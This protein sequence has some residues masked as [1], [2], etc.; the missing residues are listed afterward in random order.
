VK[1]YLGED[2]PDRGLSPGE[3]VRITPRKADVDYRGVQAKARPDI[4]LSSASLSTTADTDDL[5]SLGVPVYRPKSRD[6]HDPL[7]SWEDLEP[8]LNN[9]RSH[10]FDLELDLTRTDISLTGPTG[11]P[12][13]LPSTPTSPLGGSV[14]KMHYHY[15]EGR[16]RS[17]ERRRSSGHSRA[18]SGER[19]SR[20]RTPTHV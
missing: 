13:V 17:M 4:L 5:S 1:A 9:R 12:V 10:N 2:S 11:Y 19:S 6:F 8:E 15:P 3:V 18:R 20:A 16:E 14:Q 7:D